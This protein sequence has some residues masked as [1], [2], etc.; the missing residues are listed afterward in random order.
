MNC[1]KKIP[2]RR[3]L[4]A[5]AS[6]EQG[7]KLFRRLANNLPKGVAHVEFFEQIQTDKYN[8]VVITYEPKGHFRS[9]FF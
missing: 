3:Q 9:N 1:E 7:E 6:T 4:Y 8:K 2:G 5:V